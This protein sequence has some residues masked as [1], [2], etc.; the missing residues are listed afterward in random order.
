MKEKKMRVVAKNV[1]T[2]TYFTAG[3]YYV[4]NRLSSNGCGG[5]VTGDDGQEC[6]IHFPYSSHIDDNSWRVVGERTIRKMP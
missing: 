1:G 6:F 4:V 5:E 2:C 3:K